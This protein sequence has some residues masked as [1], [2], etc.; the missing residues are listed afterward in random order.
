MSKKTRQLVAILAVVVVVGVLVG[1]LS[2]LPTGN[3]STTTSSN[4]GST[5]STEK[6]YLYEHEETDVKTVVVKNMY[7]EFTFKAEKKDDDV[8]YAVE[9]YEGLTVAK[10]IVNGA[11][12]YATKLEVLREIG[13]VEKLADYGLKDPTAE[14]KVTYKNGDQVEIWIGDSLNSNA[15]HRYAIEKG[16]KKVFVVSMESL[17]KVK[18]TSLL[19]TTLVNVATTNEDGESV[20]PEFNYIKISGRDHAERIEITKVDKDKLHET[21]PLNMFAYYLKHPSGAPL[22]GSAPN[23]YLLDMCSITAK[24][25]AV[26]N[27]TKAQLTEH[28]FDDPINL[29]FEIMDSEGSKK[30][31][32]LKIGHFNPNE[33]AYVM[34][35]DVNVIYVVNQSVLKIA[36][37]TPH[38]LRDDLLHIVSI[39]TVSA[40]DIEI[41]DVKHELVHER[42]ERESSSSA[43]TSS[44]SEEV[45]YDYETYCN[46]ELLSSF[47]AYYQQFLSAMKQEEFTEADRKGELLFSITLHYYDEFEQEPTVYRIYKCDTNE[48]RAVFEVDGEAISLVNLSWANKMIE[49][50]DR[51]LKGESITVVY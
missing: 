6:V 24:D 51:L 19:S 41:G 34:L 21:D 44:G 49:D 10:S 16:S 8:V 11:T 4:T 35:E 50:T 31:F 37:M 39:R 20:A 1:V 32:S 27:P 12:S 22:D 9:G 5:T 43:T 33:T 38:E 26:V 14:Y 29:S 42:I 17:L 40:L 3:S 23:N 2:L 28:G 25:I 30:A 48:R 47:S 15:A 18:T 46:G 7:G 45:L 13:E 36:T